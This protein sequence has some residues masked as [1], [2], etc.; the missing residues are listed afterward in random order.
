MQ[1][2]YVQNGSL[3]MNLAPGNSIK[4]FD[5]NS[6]KFEDDYL[7]SSFDFISLDAD[8]NEFKDRLEYYSNDFKKLLESD[9]Y[10][11]SK[12]FYKYKDKVYIKFND[13]TVIKLN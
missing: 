7:N 3:Y 5:G 1:N 10:S 6:K 4:L 11:Y 9:K 2:T 12:G 8:D 13:N